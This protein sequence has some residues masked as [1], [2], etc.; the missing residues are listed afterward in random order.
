MGA[1]ATDDLFYQLSGKIW[2]PTA[3]AFSSAAAWT[4][5]GSVTLAA[6]GSAVYSLGNVALPPATIMQF[7]I[8]QG[9]ADPSNGSISR[10]AVASGATSPVLMPGAIANA[11]TN[12]AILTGLSFST[13][14]S[15]SDFGGVA[16]PVGDNSKGRL[17]IVTFTYGVGGANAAPCTPSA[18]GR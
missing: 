7:Y 15:G 16:N 4:A 2:A 5:A 14:P 13:T 11:N 1:A 12:L 9:A 6:A 3:T 10:Y 17:P 18:G 8:V